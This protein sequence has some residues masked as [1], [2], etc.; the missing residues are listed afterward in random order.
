MP[1]SYSGAGDS[2]AANGEVAGGIK[3]SRAGCSETA[4]FT[5]VW[6]NAKIHVDGRVKNWLACSQ[7]VEFLREYLDARGMFL[8]VR[9][10]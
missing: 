9:G 6:R 1:L 5:V 2:D 4:A 8:E 7:H 3:C 10:L